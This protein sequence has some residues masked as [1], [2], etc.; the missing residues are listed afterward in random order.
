MEP[1]TATPD[2]RH[3]LGGG[4]MAMQRHD[5]A[6]AHALRYHQSGGADRQGTLPGR[7]RLPTMPA[8]P[9]AIR[10]GDGPECLRRTTP[11]VNRGLS[12]LLDQPNAAA[13]QLRKV[14]WCS[15]CARSAALANAGGKPFR[16]C[17]DCEKEN[18]NG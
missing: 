2:A 5:P 15:M 12:R 4:V 11:G 14:G 6:R 17:P 13:H 9:P 7:P 16:P 10:E 18:I 8:C 3:D 1:R